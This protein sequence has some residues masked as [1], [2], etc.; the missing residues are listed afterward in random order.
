MKRLQQWYQGLITF[1]KSATHSPGFVLALGGGGSR[2]LAHLGVLEALEKHGLR[3]D[4][5]VGTS[6]GALFGALYAIH[7]DVLE[8]RKRVEH[9]LN[10]ESFSQLSLP[11]LTEA[12]LEDDSWMAKLGA[13]ARH[14]LLY[15][16]AATDIALMDAAVLEG[17]IAE[18]CHDTHF[19]DTVIP[20]YITGVSFPA[21][22]CHVFHEGALTSA[23][24][25]SMA[26]PGVFSPV[27]VDGVRYVDGGVAAELPSLEAKNIAQHQQIVVAVNVGAYPEPE[28]EPEHIISMLDWTTMVKSYHLRQFKYDYADV[29]ITPLVGTTQWHDFSHPEEEIRKGFDATEAQIP[30]L[31]AK[32]GR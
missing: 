4:A 23:V 6:I 24:S 1:K 2:G 20:L 29:M 25:A 16:K 15:T 10:S 26:I 22:K 8:V 19:A 3:P 13:A 7:G 27:V 28:S 32:L 5:I 14:T 18:F 21:G 31:L 12:K 11:P 17:I 30:Q 9:F